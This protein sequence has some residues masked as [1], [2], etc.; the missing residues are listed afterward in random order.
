M[1]REKDLQ[2]YLSNRKA[3]AEEY[4]GAW[5]IVLGQTVIETFPR[6]EEAVDFSVRRYG[7]NVASIFQA[8]AQD[9]F[10]FA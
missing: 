3:L 2:W 5:L 9:P 1:N 8:T 7:I 10:V 6:E 4:R